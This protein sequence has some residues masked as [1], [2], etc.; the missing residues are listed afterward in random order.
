MRKI[1][2]LILSTLFILP[3][4]VFGIVGFGLNVIQDGAK[5][6]AASNTEGSGLTAATVESFEMEAT[7]AGIG[8]YG[9]LDLAGWAVEF[10]ANVVGGE[11]KFSF[12]NQLAT[13]ENVPFGWGRGSTAITIKKNI[14]DFSI[15]LLA[16]TALSVGV[17]TNTHSSTPRASV[18]MVMEL[19]DVENPADLVNAEF[20]P[21]AL[22]EQLITYLEDNLIE[23]SGIHAQLGLRFKVLIADAHLNFRYNIAEDVY[24]GSDS[25]TEIQFKLGIGF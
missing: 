8:F 10:E 3:S 14:A 22:E 15:P 2:I 16:K 20:T 18:S 21:E 24:A 4:T 7:P 23:A 1:K 25:F 13:M 17:G 12:V 6:G 9:F 11:Y 19:L 5:L